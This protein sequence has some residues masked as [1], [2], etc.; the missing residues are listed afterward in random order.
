MTNGLAG[1]GT[2]GQITFMDAIRFQGAD[3]EELML[4]EAMRRSLIDSG[5]TSA[6]DNSPTSVTTPEQLVQE[7]RPLDSSSVRP[8]RGS[9]HSPYSRDHMANE[10]SQI[11]GGEERDSSSPPSRSNVG[12]DSEP[13]L[14]AAA[15]AI[16]TDAPVVTDDISMPA[17]DSNADIVGDPGDAGDG[18]DD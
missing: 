12:L 3:V 15:V 5:P 16:A 9:D 2:A 8:T 13:G 17:A 14:A 10:S 18:G 1:S 6:N 11:Q 4:M 7:P